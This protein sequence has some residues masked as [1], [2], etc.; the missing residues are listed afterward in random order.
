MV[1]PQRI[2]DVLLNYEQNVLLVDKKKLYRTVEI[3][4]ENHRL[5][6]V[7]FSCL[8]TVRGKQELVLDF[9][10]T[11]FFATGSKAKRVIKLAQEIESLDLPVKVTTIL[12][13]TEPLRTWG[14]KVSQEE[15]T[16][17]CELMIEEARESGLLPE[18]WDS[19]LWSEL[20]NLYSGDQTFVKCLEWANCAG[21]QTIAIQ[22]QAK[23]LAGF[24]NYEFPLGFKETGTRQVAAYA[25]EGAILE[26]L[27]PDALLLQS[28]W[29][30]AEK[31]KLYQW[32]RKKPLQIVHPF[33]K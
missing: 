15:M 11:L 30:W 31:D 10:Q 21:K 7:N 4:V 22:E 13:D 2:F 6:L 3:A 25:L 18:N 24:L 20:E 17:A 5:N 28:E 1:Q 27:F 19:T 26:E 16:T 23:H 9:F 8:A 12:V 32:F 14:W 29:P 33:Q